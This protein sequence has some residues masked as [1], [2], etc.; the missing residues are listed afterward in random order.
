MCISIRFSN[1]GYTSL[2]YI[3]LKYLVKDLIM[4]SWNFPAFFPTSGLCVRGVRRAT[5]YV[6]LYDASLQRL[7]L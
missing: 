6:Q 7:L 5:R 1:I 3:K 4:K 2:D